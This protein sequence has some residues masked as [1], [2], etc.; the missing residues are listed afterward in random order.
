MIGTYQ[1]YG[2]Y[3][4][5]A[6]DDGS[7]PNEPPPNPAPPPPAD[8]TPPEEPP[9]AAAADPWATGPTDGNWEAWFRKNLGRN[10]LTPAELIALEASLNKVGVQVLRNASGVAGKIRLPNGQIVDVINRAGS[11]GNGFQWLTGDGESGG[12]GPAPMAIDPSY[13]APWT[14][15]PPSPGYV[16]EFQ[17]P[18]E[19]KA[20]TADSIY[21]DPS[22]QF[23]VGEGQ[24][25]LENSAAAKGVL[26][27][28][29]TLSDIINY[30]QHAASQEYSNIFDRSFGIWNGNWNN[31]LTSFRANK[32]V[33]DDMYQRSLNRYQMARQNWFDNQDKPFSKLYQAA[34]L[35]AT[36]A[37]A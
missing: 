22:Y 5:Y 20:P 33:N 26:N 35:G 11:G 1:D 7:D 27:S 18:G 4:P 30:G 10:T 9:P 23:R 32:D 15:A 17:S 12:A 13:L 36:A 19:F 37:A 28:G 34:S 24:R 3:D 8:P 6:Q 25:A 14:E 16:P 31:A 2:Y 21:A 29:G